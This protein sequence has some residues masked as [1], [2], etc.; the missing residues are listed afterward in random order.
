[1]IYCGDCHSKM[2]YHT[3][4]VNKDIYYFTCSDNKVDYCGNCPGRHY[5]RADSLEEVV[6]AELLIKKNETTLTNEQKAN[7]EALHK[8]GLRLETVIRLYEKLYEDNAIGKVSD[9]WFSELSH[10][11]EVERLEL[12]SKIHTLKTAMSE[13]QRQKSEC[14]KFIQTVRQFMQMQKLTAPLLREL[15]D[16]ID[17]FETEGTDKNRTQRIVIYYRFIGYIVIPECYSRENYT[18]D[19]RQGVSIEYLTEPKSA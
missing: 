12:K 19:I 1:M 8:A 9:E 15:I 10:K 14:E 3:N 17:V 13:S 6:K 5:V 11:Y 16:H 2:R 7:E 18:A 4:T